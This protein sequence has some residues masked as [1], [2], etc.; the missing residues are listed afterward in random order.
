VVVPFHGR[1]KYPLA[2]YS[3]PKG[4]SARSRAVNA[5]GARPTDHDPV[6]AT[7]H[8]GHPTLFLPLPRFHRGTW[9]GP[10]SSK[11][12]PRLFGLILSRARDLYKREPR[13]GRPLRIRTARPI[14]S[15]RARTPLAR[16]PLP[17][18]SLASRLST[19][20]IK[21]LIGAVRTSQRAGGTRHSTHTHTERHRLQLGTLE[22]GRDGADGQGRRWRPREG[23]EGEGREL[24]LRR[25]EAAGASFRR[26][27]GGRIAPALEEDPQPR[28][29]PQPLP[30]RA[31]VVG[32]PF[33]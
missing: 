20:G 22:A 12:S 25:G 15:C 7:Q 29:A 5:R 26:R 13:H 10:A 2:I 32:S 19:R 4:T 14:G 18:Q 28:P 16:P 9:N 30:V 33:P 24:G 11:K 6:R 31:L 8:N 27:A 1:T 3:E 21:L 17:W 23:L